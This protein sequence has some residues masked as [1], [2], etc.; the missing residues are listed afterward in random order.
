VNPALNQAD[1]YHPNPAGVAVIVKRM[2]PA[3][4]TVL[5]QVKRG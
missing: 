4:E 5:A 1:G 2:L 3:I